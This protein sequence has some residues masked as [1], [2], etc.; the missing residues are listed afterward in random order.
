[1][2]CSCHFSLGDPRAELKGQSCSWTHLANFGKFQ[3]SQ[4]VIVRCALLHIPDTH[5]SVFLQ[6]I[7]IWPVLDTLTLQDFQIRNKLKKTQQQQKGITRGKKKA[8][9]QTGERN[10]EA[11]ISESTEDKQLTE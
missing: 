3:L 11:L 4:G 1:M 6:G 8:A 5:H 10:P 9:L 2:S 7:F